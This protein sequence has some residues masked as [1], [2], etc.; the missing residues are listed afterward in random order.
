MKMKKINLVFTVFITI[1]LLVFFTNCNNVEPTD[2]EIIVSPNDNIVNVFPGAEIE[3]EI[4]ILP[5]YENKGKVGS[6]TILEGETKLLDLTYSKQ[7]TSVLY[8]YTYTVSDEVEF[9]AIISLTIEAIEA[10]TG[11]KTSYTFSMEVFS[12]IKA[13]QLDVTPDETIV[14]VGTNEIVDIQIIATPDEI[15]NGEV[16]A[17]SIYN[18]TT[19]IDEKNYTNQTTEV[20]YNYQFSV[21]ANT[22]TKEQ[23]TLKIEATEGITNEISSYNLVINILPAIGALELE[24]TP[25]EDIVEVFANE[26]I[27]IKIKI[28]PDSLNNGKV[29]SLSIFEGTTLLDEIIY[30]DQT[31]SVIHNFQYTVASEANVNEQIALTFEAIEEL[32][33]EKTIYNFNMTVIPKQYE[34]VNISSMVLEYDNGINGFATSTPMLKISINEEDETINCEVVTP[35]EGGDIALIYEETYENTLCSPDSYWLEIFYTFYGASY[36]GAEQNHTKL[37]TY[38]G[39]YEN[40]D[41][42]TMQEMIVKEEY[43]IANN[44]Y[45][46]VAVA[47]LDAGDYVAF[48]TAEGVKGILKITAKS[49]SETGT[50][51]TSSLTCEAKILYDASIEK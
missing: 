47:N 42:E 32:T 5:D 22:L 39:E 27:D 24:V 33:Q 9:G 46:G 34:V 18:G 49:C 51:T 15:N 50:K 28:K 29:S 8:E 44:E 45:N 7:K 2:L 12:N 41:I 21:S 38:S 6:L 31:T 3:I 14:D 20:I 16:G 40:V 25:E 30:T 4:E 10:N 1:V 43:G 37:M 26:I 23:V 36:S 13:L 48:K 17:I 11:N 19:L 35:S